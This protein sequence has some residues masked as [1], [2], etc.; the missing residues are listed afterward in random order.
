MTD[1]DKELRERIS[2]LN[3]GKPDPNASMGMDIHMTKNIKITAGKLVEAIKKYPDHPVASAIAKS[4][5][6]IAPG[7][8]VIM[9]RVDV[10][11]ML[12]NMEVV[13]TTTY[14][15]FEGSRRRVIHKELGKSLGSAK[16]P[17]IGKGKKPE[18][19]ASSKKKQEE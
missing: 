3:E 9:D 12:D 13:I 16:K 19:Q 4:I 1:V 7:I 17:D 14:E 2:A 5:E 8:E 10:M 15:V 11:A 6:S 18:L